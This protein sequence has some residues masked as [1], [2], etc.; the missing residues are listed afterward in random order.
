M[1]VDSKPRAYELME[2]RWHLPLTLYGGTPSMRKAGT[3]YLPQHPKESDAAYENRLKMTVLYNFFKKTIQSLVGQTFKRPIV[4]TD[5]PE[6]LKYLEE[7]FDGSNTTIT[8]FGAGLLKN[9]LLYGKAHPYTDF[10]VNDV[11]TT[12]RDQFLRLKAFAVNVNPENVIGWR[13]STDNGYDELTEVR[14]LE[15]DTGLDDDWEEVDIFRIKVI[16]KDTIDIYEM[17]DHVDSESKSEEEQTFEYVK[18]IPN[19]LGY[20]PLGVIYAEKTGFFTSRC[21]LEDM[22]Y[23]N[24]RHWQSVSDQINILH[25]ARV[26]FIFAKGF[27]EGELDNAEIGPNRM[28]V[29]SNDASDMKYVEHTGAAIGAGQE[30]INNI[31][32]SIAMMG[33]DI[34]MASGNRA[35]RETAAAAIL[36]L[37]QSMSTIQIVVRSIEQQLKQVYVTAAKY[38]DIPEEEVEKITVTINDASTLPNDPNPTDSVLKLLQSF[39]LTEEQVLRELKR[40]GI[41]SNSLKELDL[42]IQEEIESNATSTPETEESSEEDDNNEDDQ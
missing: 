34:I 37:S 40:R 36:D 39:G 12:R 24:L 41:V 16:K 30:D 31:V 6:R 26:P 29:S 14:I 11:T 25:V 4:V 1:A 7:N 38:M 33:A 10:P 21:P 20:I 19:T 2:E 17:I 5:V 8:D 15:V 18:T 28:V 27:E 22:A 13:V 32:K 9:A 3:Q 35:D 23:L 42:N